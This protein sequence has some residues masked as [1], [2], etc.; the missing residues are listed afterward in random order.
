[1]NYKIYSFYNYDLDP[2]IPLLQ[3][4]IFDEL[5]IPICQIVWEKDFERLKTPRPDGTMWYNDHPQFLKNT[6]LKETA[7]YL[8]FFDIDCVPISSLFLD[9][10][11]NDISDDNTISGAIQSNDR[12]GTYM[13]AWFVGFARKLYF[14]CGSPSITDDNTDPFLNFTHAC[15]KKNKRVKY[16]LPTSVDNPPFGTTYEN[17]I[18]H[19]MQIRKQ[20]NHENFIKKC[21][22]VLKEL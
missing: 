4:Q 14:E 9:I 8:I 15:Y 17:L 11:L 21:K 6:I 1:M 20:S 22:L 13:S 10:I 12:F 16:W 19:E 3:K 7:D 2:E 5:K 18:Y